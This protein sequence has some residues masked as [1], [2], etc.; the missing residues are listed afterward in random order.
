MK[1]NIMYC[2]LFALL[3]GLGSFGVSQAYAE[4]QVCLYEPVDQYIDKSLIPLFENQIMTHQVTEK[5]LSVA[6]QIYGGVKCDMIV[7]IDRAINENYVYTDRSTPYQIGG[8][9]LIV[10]T[11]KTATPYL[12]NGDP[13]RVMTN[14]SCM[15][16]AHGSKYA[17]N[18]HGDTS[19]TVCNP[20]ITTAKIGEL[21]PNIIKSSIETGL[22][23]LGV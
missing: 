22:K 13:S 16:I 15:L 19:R 10:F 21:P 14:L 1:Q 2:T 18:F 3:V 9:T 12:A 7:K 4:P 8:N 6:K 5:T 11:Y 23:K 17:N 20:Y